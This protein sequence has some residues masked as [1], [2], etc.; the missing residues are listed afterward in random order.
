M[1]LNTKIRYGARALAELAR[2]PSGEAVSL[3]EIAAAQGIS[4]KYLE[5]LFAALRA[6]GL[7]R[8]QRGARGGYLLA[9]PAEQITL[10][11]V[12]A[13]LE[14]PEPYVLCTDD[15]EACPRRDQCVTRDVWA[16]MHAASMQ[17]L[18]ATTLADLAADMSGPAE[19]VIPVQ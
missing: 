19:P 10:S 6:A 7:V 15:P 11:D 1:R 3:S 2:H 5:A 4:A 16:R 14:G 9:R 13:V 18:A 17:V 8:S 12:Y